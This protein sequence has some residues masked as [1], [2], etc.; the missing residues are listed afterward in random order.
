MPGKRKPGPKQR[1]IASTACTASYPKPPE[2]GTSSNPRANG[3]GSGYDTS[4]EALNKKEAKPAGKVLSAKGDV[5]KDTR[6]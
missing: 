6:A 1:I 4:G 2:K 5:E 3:P